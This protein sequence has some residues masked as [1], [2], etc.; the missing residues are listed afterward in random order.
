MDYFSL[1][2]ANNFDSYS[3]YHD[4]QTWANFYQNYYSTV[5]AFQDINNH[6]MPP[7]LYEEIFEREPSPNKLEVDPPKSPTQAKNFKLTCEGCE[8]EYTSKKRLENHLVKCKGFKRKTSLSFPCDQCKK[9]FKKKKTLDLHFKKYHGTKLENSLKYNEKISK[10]SIFHSIQ[11]LAQSDF[12]K[13]EKT[14][15]E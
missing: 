6:Y 7:G 14:V 8:R 15:T 11:L 5:P 2:A 10:P 4:Y 1:Q 9:I 12:D 3:I 13:H